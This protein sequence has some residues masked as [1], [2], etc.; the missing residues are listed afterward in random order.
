MSHVL[1][2]PRSLLVF[3]I[4]LPMAVVIGYLLATPDRL[5]SMAVI[6]LLLVV[7]SIP[8]LLKWHHP[9]LV[10]TWNAVVNA[11]FLPGRPSVW[12]VLGGISFGIVVLNCVLNKDQ[13][14]L[15]VPSIT[16]ILVA[17]S[18]LIAI[19][20]KFTGGIGVRVF[21]SGQFGGKGYFLIWAAVIG[22]FAL[23]S[24]Q[25]P[26][27]R[28]QLYAS[29]FLLSGVTYAFSNL[30][31]VAGPTF[32]PLFYVFPVDSSVS[33]ILSDMSPDLML[34]LAGLG[35]G[36]MAVVYFLM[37]RYG[38][39]GILDLKRP[40]RLLLALAMATLSLVGGF[41]STVVILM[42]LFIAQFWLEGLFRTRLLFVL[43]LTSVLS[44]AVLAPFAAKLPP[45]MQRGLT[46]LPFIELD[47]AVELDAQGTSMW[48]LEMWQVLLPDVRNY[49]WLGKGYNI[50]PTDLYLI[51]ESVRRGLA[52]AYESAI[53]SGD[54]HN[55]P[56]SIVIPFGIYGVVLFIALL[57]A[58]GR[59]LYYNFKYGDPAVANINRFL[60][61]F[62]LAR[63][64]F[65]FTIFGAFQTDLAMFLGIFGLSISINGGICKPGASSAQE[66]AL[67]DRRPAQL[68]YQS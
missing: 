50:N 55:G 18:L 63:A 27:K 9:L 6:G 16:W 36:C 61:A 32:W 21:G 30:V 23:S 45:A 14:F 52:K 62:F 51:Q 60:Y 22:Y 64:L 2:S 41:R 46:I 49:F 57:I 10:L 20:A 54:Y 25:I 44:I 31:Y 7:I 5:T 53:I 17:L 43:L 38:I 15:H 35:F 56:L 26:A 42:L 12:V 24:Q 47:R 68:T 59:V 40:W 4:A 33:Q 29:L 3:G 34:R 1:A 66:I 37:M 19:T 13:K 48:R 65:F 58:G 28:A 39:R 8:F 11:F 67:P